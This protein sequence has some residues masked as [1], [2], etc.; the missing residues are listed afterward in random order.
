MFYQSALP[1]LARVRMEKFAYPASCAGSI[2]RQQKRAVGRG[3]FLS[4]PAKKA[5]EV[6]CC[7]LPGH[8][9]NCSCRAASLRLFLRCLGQDCS[10]K[11]QA[12][13]LPM[14]QIFTALQRPQLNI[15]RRQRNQQQLHSKPD[16]S[17]PCSLSVPLFGVRPERARNPAGKSTSGTA[18]HPHTLPSQGRDTRVN[19]CQA[20]RHHRGA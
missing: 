10:C 15:E 17:L 19:G 13:S 5:A 4:S 11:S 3:A 20:A 1:L 9:E 14:D 2:C 16:C 18:P 7:L 8:P 6:L 12:V